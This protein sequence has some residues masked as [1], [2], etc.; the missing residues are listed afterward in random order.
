M[1]DHY[2]NADD[3]DQRHWH[4]D[5]RVPIALIVTICMQTAAAIW[6]ASALDSRVSALEIRTAEYSGRGERIIRLETLIIEMGKSIDELKLL[7]R[8]QQRNRQQ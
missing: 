3:K 8:E 1:S 7:I 6:W 4:L 2:G 5:K